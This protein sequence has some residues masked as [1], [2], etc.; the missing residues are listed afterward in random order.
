M[1]VIVLDD[2]FV[3]I[4]DTTICHSTQQVREMESR[5]INIIQEY[6]IKAHAIEQLQS[7]FKQ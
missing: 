3:S 5:T 2:Y 6:T 4:F 1:V 7:T